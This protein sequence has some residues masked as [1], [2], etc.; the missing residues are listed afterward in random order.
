MQFRPIFTISTIDDILLPDGVNEY[1]MYDERRDNPWH[2]E[3][4]ERTFNEISSIL[5]KLGF[6]ITECR[7]EGHFLKYYGFYNSEIKFYI[8]INNMDYDIYKWKISFANRGE[9]IHADLLP[10]L[11][12]FPNDEEGN[13]YFYN[14]KDIAESLEKLIELVKKDR[15]GN[16]PRG[17]R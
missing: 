14:A 11:N 13:R 10:I 6:K 5:W 7:V 3:S 4:I 1:M 2:N 9:E 17:R 12:E 8:L 15:Q 16:E